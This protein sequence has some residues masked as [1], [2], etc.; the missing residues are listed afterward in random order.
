LEVP[1]QK[2]REVYS[3]PSALSIRVLLRNIPIK[4]CKPRT[5]S[6][7]ETN[8]PPSGYPE[9]GNQSQQSEPDRKM[10]KDSPPTPPLALPPT[11]AVADDSLQLTRRA[12]PEPA[13]PY[14]SAFVRDCGRILHAKA[15]RRLAGKTQVFTRRGAESDHSRSRL[16]HTLE[17]AQ[18]ARTT[19]ATLGLNAPYAEALALVH[20]IGHPP[21]GHAGEKALDAALRAHNLGFDHNLHALRIVTS[22]EERYPAFRGL[23]LTFAVR[24]G[25]IK[26]SRDY[27]AASYPELSEYLLDQQPP[28]EA[29]LIDLADEI[30]YLTADLE[31]G[32]AAGVLDLATVQDQVPLF[33]SFFTAAQREFPAANPQLL[34][35]VA[36]KQMLNALVTDLMQEVAS[37]IQTL[38]ILTLQDV[39]HAPNRL[40]RFS[41][42]IEAERNRTKRFLYA[43]LY[44]SPE[45]EAEHAHSEEVIQTLFSAWIANPELLP[46]DHLARVHEEGAPRA[47]ADY[48]AGMTDAYIEQAWLRN[49]EIASK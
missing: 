35:N 23:N 8:L 11:I 43:N 24:E 7:F 37:Q 9:L 31:D 19:A 42:P 36:L 29:Q 14:R 20:D 39:R 40:A 47:V 26:H 15:F 6:I 48:I 34:A 2:Y 45:L 32:L 33:A 17:V 44:Q 1:A 4:Y 25:I 21:Y 41:E 46:P 5:N 18:I 13:H 22:F 49:K 38:G 30:A 28:L 10:D 3:G 12:W 16:T 27:S